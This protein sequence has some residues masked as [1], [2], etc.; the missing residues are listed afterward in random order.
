MH[1]ILYVPGMKRNLFS[2][3]FVAKGKNISAF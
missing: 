2:V 1:D 3:K